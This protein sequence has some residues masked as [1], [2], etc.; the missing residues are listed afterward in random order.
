MSE[1]LKK[2]RKFRKR[3]K[4][5]TGAGDCYRASQTGLS[6]IH[7]AFPN[8]SESQWLVHG[9][10]LDRQDRKY[11]HAWIEVVEAGEQI[12]LDYSNHQCRIQKREEY[13]SQM[14]VVDHERYTNM[15]A[16]QKGLEL[17]RKFTAYPERF[18]APDINYGQ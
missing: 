1:L 4:A 11:G 12:V 16:F 9:L 2:Y 3:G 17:G 6:K 8:E 5:N 18:N 10:C 14:R 13:Y 15:Q 7:D